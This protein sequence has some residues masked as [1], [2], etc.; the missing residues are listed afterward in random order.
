LSRLFIVCGDI[1]IF[2]QQNKQIVLYPEIIM[3]LKLPRGH[4]ELWPTESQIWVISK[5]TISS[6]YLICQTSLHTVFCKVNDSWRL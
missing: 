2:L 1:C 4:S 6:S 3:N 5:V